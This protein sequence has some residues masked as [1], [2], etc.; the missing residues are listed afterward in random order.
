M[1]L[2][3]GTPNNRR[4]GEAPVCTGRHNHEVAGRMA[5]RPT[6]HRLKR[7]MEHQRLNISAVS[8]VLFAL[9]LEQQRSWHT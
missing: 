5:P 6:N 1:M 9:Q 7:L 3:S 2:W 4:A 8:G